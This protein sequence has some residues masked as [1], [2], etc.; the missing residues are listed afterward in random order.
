MTTY[1]Q[2]LPERAWLPGHAR[3][4]A[5][6]MSA[7][8]MCL[9]KDVGSV[10]F[11]PKWLRTLRP[12]H[13]PLQDRLPW[14]NFKVIRWLDRFLKPSMNVFEYG[15]GGSTPFVAK[16]VRRLVTVEHD[17]R[18]IEPVAEVLRT[19]GI[20]NC[21]M[22]LIPPVEDSSRRNVPFGPR[23][24]TSMFPE[25]AG[26][27]FESYARRIDAYPDHSFDLVIV[28]GTARPSAVAHAIPKVVPRGHLLL[29]DS[30]QPF[31]TPALPLLE[32]FPR[33]D[34]VGVNPFQRYLQQSSVWRL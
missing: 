14:M 4:R 34:F 18:W 1:G 33:Q 7:M 24:Y 15:A 29:D 2:A 6:R 9:Y 17:P 11:L 12:G 31:S 26:Y 25:A 23:S 20:T 28:D 5:R 21:E 10:V 22:I 27:S 16:R 3:E 32:G 13:S 19:D 8:A 30:D